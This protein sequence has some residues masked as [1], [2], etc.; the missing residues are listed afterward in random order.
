MATIE[1]EMAD[2]AYASGY[3]AELKRHHTERGRQEY[4]RQNP[5]ARR[6]ERPKRASKAAKTAGQAALTVAAPE[7]GAAAGGAAKAGAGGARGRTAAAATATGSGSPSTRTRTR[8]RKRGPSLKSISGKT[9]GGTLLAEYFIAA[10]VI[11]FTLFTKGPSKGYQDTITNVILRLSALTAVFFILF[12]VA[13][14]ERAG[15]AAMWFGLLIDLAV[16]LNAY[17]DDFFTGFKSIATG[18]PMAVDTATLT[19]S[20]NLTDP[21]PTQLPDE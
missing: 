2:E 17:K 21:Q 3:T 9:Y 4:F 19:A 10:F 7:A 20:T 14:S 1:K 16:V 6:E 18:Q 5:D 11:S 12:L 15:K 8:S 13:S